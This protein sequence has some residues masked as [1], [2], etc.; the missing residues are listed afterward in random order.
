MLAGSRATRVTT[1][2]DAERARLLCLQRS[3][4]MARFDA[5]SSDVT[6]ET[7]KDAIL[8]EVDAQARIVTDDYLAYR[9]IGS[10]YAG[11]HESV[12]HSTREYVRG[13]VHTNT[14]ESSFALL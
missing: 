12:C 1:S 2:A 7:L 9:G 3:N 4:A 13:D 10:E 5:G 14:A 8:E 11:G 6:G